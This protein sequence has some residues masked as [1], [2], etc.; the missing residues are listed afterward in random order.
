VII[1]DTNLT[2]CSLFI[3]ATEEIAITKLRLNMTSQCNTPEINFQSQNITI[4]DIYLEG[5]RGLLSEIV[6]IVG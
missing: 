3:I 1:I 5:F 2:V 4:N 6:K